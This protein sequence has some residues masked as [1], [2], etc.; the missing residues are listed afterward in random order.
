VE[1]NGRVSK[2]TVV[3][4]SGSA[5]D[6][7]Q[8]GQKR[9]PPTALPDCCSLPS[10]PTTYTPLPHIPLN[11]MGTRGILENALDAVGHTPLIRLS[12]IA[13]QHGLKC[14]LRA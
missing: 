4:G 12:K 10:A 9:D 8:P 5:G 14:N 13:A 3:A 7:A 1:L 2:Q 11:I 6:H